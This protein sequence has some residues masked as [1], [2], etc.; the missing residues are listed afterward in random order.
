MKTL[1]TTALAAALV[2]GSAMAAQAVT[3]FA[4]E[5][6]IVEDGPRGPG[7]RAD[8]ENAL[9]PTDGAFFELGFGATVDFTFGVDFFSSATVTEVSFGNPAALG[10][11]ATVFVGTGGVFTEIGTVSA[12]DA[13]APGQT[14]AVPGTFDTLRLTDISPI[15]GGRT[16]GGFDVDSVSVSAIPL[17]AAGAGLLAGLGALTLLRRRRAA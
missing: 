12:V 3:V 6:T 14:I 4:T 17:P 7:A 15:T 11:A 5:A 1:K 9:G 8:I 16:A 13:Q 2:A 10:E